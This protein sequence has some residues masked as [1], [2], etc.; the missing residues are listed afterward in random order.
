MEAG[1]EE[2]KGESVS[3]TRL[4]TGNYLEA[5]FLLS[6]LIVTIL[7][8]G[9]SFPD[10]AYLFSPVKMALYVFLAPAIASG[11]NLTGYIVAA[12]TKTK[13][14]QR[15]FSVVFL[16]LSTCSVVF[17][18]GHIF[19]F[20]WLWWSHSIAYTTIISAATGIA[21]NVAMLCLFAAKKC[22]GFFKETSTMKE[23]TTF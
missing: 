1:H 15:V 16:S 17:Y 10:W 6:P 18:A 3:G 13:K 22:F 2:K 11:A 21:L 20:A 12:K 23:S 14:T 8:V 7:I 4:R 19:S 5:L 9:I